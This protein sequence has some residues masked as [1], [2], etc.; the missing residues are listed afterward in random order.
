[1]MAIA[2]ERGDAEVQLSAQAYVRSFYEDLGFVA[3]GAEYIE[4]G[5]VHV[6]MRHVFTASA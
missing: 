5:I 4:A 2:R 1:M 3:E 6:Y